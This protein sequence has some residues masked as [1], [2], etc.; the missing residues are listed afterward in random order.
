MPP[1]KE[2]EDSGVSVIIDAGVES[3]DAG[4]PDSGLEPPRDEPDA[5][6]DDAGIIEV[7]AGQPELDAG[8]A[9]Q[10]AGSDA[11]IDAGQP[12]VD[13]GT[14]VDA[15]VSMPDAGVV[16]TTALLRPSNPMPCADPAVFSERN[17]GQV[18]YV[19]CTS[20]SHV[21]KTTDWQHF[22]DVRSS[23]TFT[24][25]G[26]SANGQSVGSWWAP[27]IIY[28]PGAQL[29]VMW[30]SVPDAQGTRD[31]SGT[32]DTRSIAVFTSPA[33]TGPWTFKSIALDGTVG[34]QYIDPFLFLD[35][36]GGH[37][38]FWK[39]YGGGLNSRIVGARVNASWEAVT[40]ARVDI[41]NGYGG[42]GTWEDNV[43][44]NP[45][46]WFDPA[47][48]RHHLL[49]SGGHWF[50]DTY[51]TGHAV[52]SCGPLCPTATSGGWHITNSGDRGV[53]QVVRSLGNTN[54]TSGG[55]GGAVFLDDNADVII[56]AAAAKSA[57]GTTTRYL[58]RD[59]VK[60]KND[61]PYVNTTG[62]EPLGY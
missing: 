24:L 43:R 33:P 15:G 7:D 3:D 35:H 2:D 61:A 52:S 54:F 18:F 41:I 23:T 13:A 14:R 9:E 10:D 45:A 56:Y 39:Q 27:G 44:E 26:L 19:F 48:Q 42:T 8:V 11:G 53:V 55:P 36:D 30:V 22:T 57:A 16:F 47:T 1:P 20:M 58:M 25:T 46:V 29:Y 51:A 34:Q 40:G 32:W 21:W 49:F 28:A 4:E 50:N 60:W 6:V 31:A 62:H 37:Y 17:A 5:S 59:A 38:V 12:I